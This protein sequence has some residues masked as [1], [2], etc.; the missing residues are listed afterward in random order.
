MAG[1]VPPAGRRAKQGV[2]RP[3]GGG[4]RVP[5]V[6]RPPSGR[7]AGRPL[8]YKEP[9]RTPRRF[10]SCGTP[11]ARE[12]PRRCGRGKAAPRR[13]PTS[14]ASLTPSP[15]LGRAAVAALKHAPPPDARTQPRSRSG[16]GTSP[17][18]FPALS[19][20]PLQAR[21]AWPFSLLSLCHL[22]SFPGHLQRVG[23]A[24]S[25]SSCSGVG[26]AR[27]PFPAGRAPL[28]VG[29]PVVMANQVVTRAHLLFPSSSS[30]LLG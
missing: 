20:P 25:G 14:P 19:P 1:G 6:C 8:P 17:E 30:S 29:S 5:A 23:D 9:C 15:L 21:V 13:P 11:V 26:S 22:R 4:E 3:V 28:R 18:R 16:P 7:Q 27:P 10:T 24:A 2:G 12:P